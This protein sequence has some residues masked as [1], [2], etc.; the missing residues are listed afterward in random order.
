MGKN[1]ETPLDHFDNKAKDWHLHYQKPAFKQRFLLFKSKLASVVKVPAKILDFGCGSGVMVCGL[2]QLGYEVTGVDGSEG[3]VKAARG[4][5]SENGVEN[6]VFSIIDPIGETLPKEEYDAVICSSVLEYV[7]KDV[8]LLK[9]LIKSL[10]PNGYLFISVPNSR[11]ILGKIEDIAIRLKLRGITK[12]GADVYQAK[13]RYD[14][15]PFVHDMKKLGLHHIKYW[16]FEIPVL[17][18]TGWVL[19]NSQFIGVMLLVSGCKK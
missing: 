10:R 7:E 8:K 3:M 16:Y 12:N 11:S 18:R 14:R 4:Y 1:T 2:T 17:G 6:I 13:R 5:A 15:K 9:N 19:S